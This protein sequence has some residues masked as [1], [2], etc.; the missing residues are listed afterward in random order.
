MEPEEN[1]PDVLWRDSQA[2]GHATKHPVESRSRGQLWRDTF[3]VIGQVEPLLDIREAYTRRINASRENRVPMTPKDRSPQAERI[4][5]LRKSVLKLDQVAFAQRLDVKQATVSR[6]ESGEITPSR[7][8]YKELARLAP[9]NSDLQRQLLL[10]GGF[11]NPSR[12]IMDFRE[13]SGLLPPKHVGWDPELMSIVVEAL[14][15]KYDIQT[16]EIS[17]REFAEKLIAWYESCHRMK[18]DDPAMVVNFLK[19]A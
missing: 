8:M 13:E 7:A 18:L 6:W 16:G 11:E 2:A 17:P 5:Q 14:S 12:R 4:F 1:L 19:S 10:D 9:I 15:R 3:K